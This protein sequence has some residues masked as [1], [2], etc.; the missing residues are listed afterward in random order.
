MNNVN[1]FLHRAP[2]SPLA[3]FHDTQCRGCATFPSWQDNFFGRE[4]MDVLRGFRTSIGDLG[5]ERTR[6]RGSAA[7]AAR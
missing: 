6:H 7:I 3:H 1:C 2:P 5:H 4:G